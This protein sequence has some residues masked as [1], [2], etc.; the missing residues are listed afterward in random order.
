MSVVEAVEGGDYAASLLAL[1]NKLAA[2]VDAAADK[3]LIHLA[4]LSKALVDVLDKIE[5]LPMPEAD[6]VDAAR[7]AT[8]RLIG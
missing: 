3:R 8:L 5:S 4:P 7:A 6:S 2:G 1:R